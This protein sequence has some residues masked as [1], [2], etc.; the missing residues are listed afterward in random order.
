MV[1]GR[2]NLT[3]GWGELDVQCCF[4]LLNLPLPVSM[5]WMFETA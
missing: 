5:S 3:L 2:G 4:L 1:N